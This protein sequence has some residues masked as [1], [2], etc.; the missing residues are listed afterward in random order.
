MIIEAG[1]FL[2]GMAFM[3]ITFEQ[4]TR[5][6]DNLDG[7]GYSFGPRGLFGIGNEQEV[8]DSVAM[9]GGNI[10]PN[11]SLRSL[12]V[13]DAYSR[14][15][16]YAFQRD[17]SIAATGNYG[18]DLRN[19]LELTVRTVQNNLKIVLAK[20]DADL[21]SG[22]YGLKTFQYIKEYQQSKGLP[23]TGLAN[24]A[25]QK[26]L[27]EDARR[28]LGKPSKDL[29]TDAQSQLNRITELKA[30]LD[31]NSISRDGFIEEVRRLLP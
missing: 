24:A 29:A 11:N 14:S 16:I 4:L 28:L 31:K 22:Y 25:V 9:G 23:V 2:S 13:L 26:M 30:L 15:A 21:I 27:N 6:R 7:L 17:Q 20:K 18:D 5:L 19:R 8:F 3:N 1:K 10:T 12:A